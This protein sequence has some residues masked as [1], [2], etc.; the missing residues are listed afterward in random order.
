MKRHGYYCR[1]RG[2]NNNPR[3]RSCISCAKSKARCDNGRPQCTRCGLKGFECHYPA[4]LYRNAKSKVPPNDDAVLEQ[5]RRSLLSGVEPIPSENIYQPRNNGIMALNDGVFTT[6]PEYGDTPVEQIDWNHG[7]FDFVDFISPQIS[8]EATLYL[9]ATPLSP[10]SHSS[11]LASGFGQPLQLIS[12]FD[13]SLPPTPTFTVRSLNQRPRL[14][15][16]ARRTASLILSTL[17]SYAVMMLRDGSL[18]PFIHPHLFSSQ[19][20]NDNMEPLNNCKSL[21]HMISKGNQGSRKL[22]WRNV[23]MESERLREKVCKQNT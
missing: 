10:N 23:Q 21:V 6:R 15:A 20:D 13:L 12:P 19:A 11:S 7:D 4:P 14:E 5:R 9:P 18:P 1:S 22:F 8:D 2:D 17:K 3:S 16:G